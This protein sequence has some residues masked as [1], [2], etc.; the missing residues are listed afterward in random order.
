MA[1][2][3]VASQSNFGDQ[4]VL[5]GY[6]LR[7]DR[8][9]SDELLEMSLYWRVLAPLDREYSIAVHLVDDRNWRYGQHDSQHPASYPTS[10]WQANEYAR[11][12]HRLAVWPGTPP[13]VYTILVS[14]YDRRSDRRLDLLDANGTPVGTTYPLT[15]VQVI[16]PAR[17]LLPD[18]LEIGQPF[19]TD[20][21][22][23]L[24]LLGL[25]LPSA[26]V[27]S[28]EQLPLTLF[29]QAH[30]IPTAD[31]SARARLVSAD[32]I[33]VAERLAVPG[34]ADYPT[35]TWRTGDLLRDSHSLPVPA[36][37]SNSDYLLRLDL[38]DANNIPVGQA[39]DLAT[40]TI[41]APVRTFDPPNPQHV[42]DPDAI[43][44]GGLAT[45]LGYDLEIPGATL[46][47]GQ[48]WQLTLYWQALATADTGYTVFVHLLDTSDDIHAQRDQFPAAGARP[49]TGW[50]AGE[51]IHDSHEL[52]VA[53]DAPPGEY[54]LEVGIYDPVT[55][56]RLPLLDAD[57]QAIDSRALLP[58]WLRVK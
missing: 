19:S 45:L 10:R 40:V 20:M 16:R 47:P 8:I 15:Q 56:R 14:V 2:T 27:K 29:W 26:E 5:M 55:G 38:L 12:V 49:T 52:T 11:D 17:P 31:Y 1:G 28:G 58:T 24:T 23:G 32:G 7:T 6:D 30:T 18:V 4:M 57:G 33:V 37:I 25:N 54:R 41:R 46:I 42:F 3:Q 53:A 48:T 34:R 13:G 51:I 43:N 21:G 44:V 35:S 50:V 36:A 9:P 22:G 39:V